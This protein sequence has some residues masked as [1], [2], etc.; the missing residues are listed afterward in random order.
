MKVK[1]SRE[2]MNLFQSQ[3]VII[4]YESAKDWDLEADYIIKMDCGCYVEKCNNQKGY[5]TYAYKDGIED[6]D[7]ETCFVWLYENWHKAEHGEEE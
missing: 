1:I 2:I 4:D 5:R 7:L 3:K 6:L